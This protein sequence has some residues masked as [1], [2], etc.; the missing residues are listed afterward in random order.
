MTA[1]A[2]APN[3][4]GLCLCGCG[5]R[6][7][8][9]K[10]TRADR[11]LVRG[12]PSRFVA[13]HGGSAFRSDRPRWRVCPET[14]CW[15]WTGALNED[16]YGSTNSRPETQAHRA[17]WHRLV[18]PIAPG[19]ELDHL[20]RVRACVNPDHLEP[21]TQAVNKR[22]AAGWTCAPDGTPLL[23]GRGHDMTMAEAIYVRPGD[24]RNE[25]RR[26]RNTIRTRAAAS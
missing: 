17:V 19:M 25:C 22:R 15:L 26:C 2:I 3:P 4:T 10:E 16:G 7:P 1:V 14:G 5:G 11:G 9:A 6:T 8:L 23:C 13:R 24:G 12:Q 18:G 20:C 21:V